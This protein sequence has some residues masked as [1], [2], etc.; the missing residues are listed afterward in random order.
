MR[1][2]GVSVSVKLGLS[3]SAVGQD[4][5]FRH[6]QDAQAMDATRIPGLN[7]SDMHL[8]ANARYAGRTQEPGQ[9]PTAGA[10]SVRRPNGFAVRIIQHLPRAML[11]MAGKRGSIPTFGG[12][13]AAR[14]RQR[15]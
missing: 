14:T 10:V 1:G 7:S 3:Q 15:D 12:N 13:D 8:G 6:V 5:V 4:L 2:Q 11:G 9:G